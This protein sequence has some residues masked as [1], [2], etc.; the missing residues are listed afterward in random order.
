MNSFQIHVEFT[1]SITI[2]WKTTYQHIYI[3]G[4]ALWKHSIF[5]WWND[6]ICNIQRSMWS[7]A[8]F[9]ETYVEVCTR[10]VLAERVACSPRPRN[11]THAET[12]YL[13][14][15]SLVAKVFTQH[16]RGQ[17]SIPHEYNVWS[18]QPIIAGIFLKEV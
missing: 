1:N 17:G 7:I 3:R 15:G 4:P 16:A 14:W 10:G 6:N 8:N 18:P 9:T 5:W 13:P 12:Y 2:K 11:V